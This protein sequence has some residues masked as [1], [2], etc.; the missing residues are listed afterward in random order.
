MANF[1]RWLLRLQANLLLWQV[2]RYPVDVVDSVDELG[3][4]ATETSKRASS[5]DV[6]TRI[7]ISRLI[8]ERRRGIRQ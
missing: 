4:L 1:L 7:A 8:V 6:A 2:R 5:L 3:V